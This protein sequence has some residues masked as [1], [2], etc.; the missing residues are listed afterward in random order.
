MSGAAYEC[1]VLCTDD[2]SFVLTLTMLDADGEPFEVDDYDFE[3]SV[4]G[5]GTE[6]LLTEGSGITI[7]SPTATATITP[8]LTYR[9]ARGSYTHGF[10]KTNI[11]TGQVDQIFDGTVTVTEG[12]F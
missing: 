9:L 12:N 1:T 10:R 8:G 7:D 6:L 3:Y 5:C 11:A 2:E 4:K